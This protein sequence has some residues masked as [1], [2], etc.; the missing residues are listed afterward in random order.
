[1]PRRHRKKALPQELITLDIE[2]LSHDGRGIAHL[3]G[4]TIFVF[5]ALPGERV[6]CRYTATHGRFDEVDTVDVLE[7][8]PQRVSP[9]CAHF[10]VC[11]G[12]NLQHIAPAHQ[13]ELKQN[14]LLEQLQHLGGVEPEVILPPLLGPSWGY[15]HKARMGAKY[16]HKKET[17]L[18]GFRE[19][20]SNFLAQLEGC[21]ILH[22]SVGRC[23]TDLRELINSLSVRHKIAQIEVA[24]GDET[25]AL[26]LRNLEPLSDADTQQLC[27]FAKGSGLHLYLQPGGLKTIAPLWPETAANLFYD[28]PDEAVR[29]QF[30]PT[31]FT[32]VNPVLNRQ[33]VAQAMILLDVQSEER[34]L[35]LF[36]GLGNF[37]L[38]LAKRA[39]HVTAIEGEASL[40]KRADENAAIHDLHNIQYH[41]ANLMEK[42]DGEWL[43]GQYDKL[44][45][46]PPRSGA[47][48][49]LEQ[50]PLKDMQRIVYV[51]CNQATLARDAGIL[52]KDKGFKLMQAGVMDMFPHT[53]HVEAMALFSR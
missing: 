11:G 15:R 38:P 24:V 34:V 32:Q 35:E 2:S 44:L 22:E 18:V 31:D 39:L 46:D 48:A 9:Q 4:K 7:A 37:T 14:T 10:G 47:Q 20:Q 12:C 52:V 21:E 13:I 50:L 27:D 26:I 45:L 43:H 28:L 23:I 17:M 33:M 3:D 49:I 41:V 6:N 8:S 25:T 19:K 36:C 42:I 40:V 30:Q 5:G 16:V 1:M 29:I 53:A 51:S